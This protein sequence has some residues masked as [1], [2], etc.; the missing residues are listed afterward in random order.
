[1]K[2]SGT[3]A[4]LH[5]IRAGMGFRL[6][7]QSRT[8]TMLRSSSNTVT[9]C[10]LTLLFARQLIPLIVAPVPLL[11]PRV[12]LHGFP[13]P[14]LIILLLLLPRSVA[15]L[16]LLHLPHSLRTPPVDFVWRSLRRGVAA[17]FSLTALVPGCTTPGLGACGLS[18]AGSTA[19]R[20]GWTLECNCRNPPE[21]AG[22][23]TASSSSSLEVETK[24]LLGAV[25][26]RVHS[27]L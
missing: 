7:G 8:Q 26:E 2:T 27:L 18:S 12:L 9:W 17:R 11:F 3:R 15:L 23:K 25:N 6:A 16:H 20:F 13:V 19:I 24:A 22:L 14:H 21:G 5:P 1:M 4:R 10:V